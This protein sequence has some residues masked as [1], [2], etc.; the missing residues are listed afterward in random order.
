M[1]E[2]FGHGLDGPAGQAAFHFQEAGDLGLGFGLGAIAGEGEGSLL[3][4]EFGREGVENVL[5]LGALF[6]L[7][8]DESLQSAEGSLAFGGKRRR[9]GF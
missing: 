5:D 2:R 9:R 4:G 3:L 8:G 7:F 1:F 6:E